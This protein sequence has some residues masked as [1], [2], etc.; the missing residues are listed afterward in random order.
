ML[1]QSM[2]SHNQLAIKQ[3]EAANQTFDS[4]TSQGQTPPSD[5]YFDFQY[6]RFDP[7]RIVSTS[8]PLMTP[9]HCA[10]KTR[11]CREKAHR[12]LVHSRCL[13]RN[14]SFNSDRQ[15]LCFFRSISM[16]GLNLTSVV[17]FFLND[18]PVY[19]LDWQV[20]GN[21]NACRSR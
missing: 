10:A 21:T 3:N 15:N 16:M 19:D 11:K 9:S 18:D 7:L 2:T 8:G 17:Y 20:T 6:P 1:P 5:F 4:R 12:E 13:N 14:I